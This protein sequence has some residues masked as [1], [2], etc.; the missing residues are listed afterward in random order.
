MLGS[1][2]LR[3]RDSSV[4]TKKQKGLNARPV[5]LHYNNKVNVPC[6]NTRSFEHSGLM[7]AVLHCR[8]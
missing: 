8:G 4:K 3:I 5:F 2:D 7:N 6:W 1:L